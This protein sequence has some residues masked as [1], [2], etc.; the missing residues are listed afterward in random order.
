MPPF[1]FQS[2]DIKRLLLVQMQT[3]A[4]DSSANVLYTRCCAF[5]KEDTNPKAH[6]RSETGLQMSEHKQEKERE[7]NR[8]CQLQGNAKGMAQK[9]FDSQEQNSCFLI[10]FRSGR[11][12]QFNFESFSLHLSLSSLKK[13]G[14][15]KKKEKKLIDSQISELRQ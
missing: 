9:L 13:E 15:R 10:L 7:E 12:K 11:I 5:L 2:S 1:Q 8:A 14:Q 6:K 4:L 3:I